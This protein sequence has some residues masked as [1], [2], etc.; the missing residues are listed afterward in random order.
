MHV[1]IMQTKMF[2]FGN[3]IYC[4]ISSNIVVIKSIFSIKITMKIK[5]FYSKA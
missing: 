3:N 2:W 1:A 4:A 5:I